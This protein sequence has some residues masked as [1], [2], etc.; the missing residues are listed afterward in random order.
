[1][2]SKIPERVIPTI[3][4]EEWEKIVLESQSANKILNS[5]DF[6][7]LRDYLKK[8]KES[9]I[10][11]VATNSIHD[12]LETVN[13]KDGGSKTIKTTKEEQLN[14]I[15]GCIKFIDK[16]F[17]DLEGFSKEESEYLKL[18]DDKKVIIEVTKEDAQREV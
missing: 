18:A 10:L 4:V 15:A 1:M 3:P 14:E 7:F 8:A 12:V 9:A 11:M 2:N 5:P 13:Y 6:V 17:V 16:I